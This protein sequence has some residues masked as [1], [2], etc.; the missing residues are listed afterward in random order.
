MMVLLGPTEER[1]K[2]DAFIPYDIERLKRE[3]EPVPL[4]AGICKGE[5]YMFVFGEVLQVR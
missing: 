2:K 3:A 4:M 5:G 1:I